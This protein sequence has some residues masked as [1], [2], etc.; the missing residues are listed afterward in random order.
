MISTVGLGRIPGEKTRTPAEIASG[1]SGE[2]TPQA[3]IALVVAGCSTAAQG[4]GHVGRPPRAPDPG[5]EQRR[6][7]RA[8]VP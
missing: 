6:L 3:I 5:R 8:S 4:C 2:G 1:S 7:T